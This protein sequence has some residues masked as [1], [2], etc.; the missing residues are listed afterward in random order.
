MVLFLFS[1]CRIPVADAWMVNHL[2]FE[3]VE[4]EPPLWIHLEI[5]A[6]ERLPKHVRQRSL[7]Y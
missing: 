1:W 7:L 3:T 6:Q 4:A 5:E 2:D